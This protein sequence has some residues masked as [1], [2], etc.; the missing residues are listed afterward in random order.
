MSGPP[1]E[2]DGSPR[3]TRLVAGTLAG[4]VAAGVLAGGVY[5]MT[6]PSDEP[7]RPAGPA[8]FPAEPLLVRMDTRPGWPESCH[9]DIGLFKPG[10]PAATALAGGDRCE[11]LPEP[12]PDRE[13]IAFTRTG[14]GKSEA[15]VMNA[16]GS[17]ARKVTDI[18]GGRVA[19]SPDGT[20]LAYM[21]RDGG[22][23]QIFTIALEGGKATQLTDD[24][25]AKDDPMW[26]AT[27]RLVFWSKRDG[28]EQIYT[29]DPERPGSEWTRLTDDGVRS[30]DP[31]WSPDGS[32][33]AFTRGSPE[34]SSIWVMNADGSGARAVT[35][36][37]RD[38]MDPAWSSDGTWLCFVR[39]SLAEPVV[40]AVR[41]DGTGERV[42]TPEGRTFGHPS[43][44]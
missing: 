20:R 41:A 26:S 42:L 11:M 13:H 22:T 6:R 40:H 25:S 33:I 39:G 38:D 34:H 4:L 43:W 5:Y 29:L 10:E 19:W 24:D 23:R 37:G 8:A 44:M 17:G 35:T 16:D 21:G 2:R 9:G 27:K 28:T 14:G 30:V 7:E 36:G 31:E 15:W 3:R 12:S 32:K 1:D 18:A